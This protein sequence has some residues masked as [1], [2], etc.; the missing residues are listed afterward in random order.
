MTTRRQI[1]DKV[2]TDLKNATAIEGQTDHP[3]SEADFLDVRE[4]YM[5]SIS[6]TIPYPILMYLRHC[7]QIGMQAEVIKSAITETAW[8]RTPSPRYLRAI[9]IRYETMD[10]MT[11]DDVLRDKEE[12]EAEKAGLYE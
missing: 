7:L 12:H 2:Q 8:C 6:K 3:V 10:I 1:K 9:L 4:C 11:Y 5:K